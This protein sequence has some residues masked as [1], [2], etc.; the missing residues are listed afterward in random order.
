MVIPSGK[1]EFYLFQISTMFQCMDLVT[2]EIFFLFQ[3]SNRYSTLFDVI[4]KV[5]RSMRYTVGGSTI[6]TSHQKSLCEICWNNPI[7]INCKS[8]T[9]IKKSWQHNKKSQTINDI[10]TQIKVKLFFLSF[11]SMKEIGKRKAWNIRQIFSFS[12]LFKIVTTKENEEGKKRV[13]ELIFQKSIFMF[14][15]LFA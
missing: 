15:S 10:K 11:F 7:K 5:T 12:I 4:L 6:K 2:F 14:E 8:Q 9:N 13:K 1:C 3:I